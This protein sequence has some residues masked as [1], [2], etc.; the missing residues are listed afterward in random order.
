MFKTIWPGFA[1][2]KSY[3]QIVIY[4]FIPWNSEFPAFKQMY[5]QLCNLCYHNS[6][7]EHLSQL[8]Y[9]YLYKHILAL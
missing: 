5:S 6:I 3:K 1:F 2:R 7:H 8:I 4:S 9:L